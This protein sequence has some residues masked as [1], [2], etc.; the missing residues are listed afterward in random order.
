MSY[1]ILA[2]NPGHNGSA[3]LVSDGK[4]VRFIEE[5]RLTRIKSGDNYDINTEL[6]APKIQ[7]YTGINIP[8][9]DYRIFAAPVP[10]AYARKV[11]KNDY[12]KVSHHTAHCYGSYFTSGMEG[13]VM[14]IS[15][16][17]GGQY[18][19]M[20]VYLCEDGKMNLSILDVKGEIL[21][22][23]QFTLFAST[24]KGNRPSYIA[25]AKHDISI[26]LYEAMIQQLSSAMGAPIQTGVFGADMKVT[27]V[28]DGPVT[29]IMDSKNKE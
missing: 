10:D 17:G 1:N 13:K 8:D 15:Y 19:V 25:A 4:L 23:S 6:T 27:L 26:P 11:S 9:A 2:I 24:K 28:N 3:A 7:E 20:K 29:I 5:E 14:T 18:T 21:L 12:E 22:I 16:D